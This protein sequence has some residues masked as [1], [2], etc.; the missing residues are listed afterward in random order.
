MYEG[1]STLRSNE[2]AILVIRGVVAL[3][4]GIAAVFWPGL[5]LVTL[6]YLFSAFILLSGIMT[7][8]TTAAALMDRGSS[9][10]LMKVLLALLGIVEIGVAVYMLRHPLL[11]IATFILLIGFSLIVRGVVET[12]TTLHG[13]E[14][15]TYKTIVAITGAVSVLAGV[16]ILLQPAAG[17]VAFVWVLGLF[18]LINGSMLV[19]LSLAL[20]KE[21]ELE[22]ERT[23]LLAESKGRRRQ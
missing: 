13:R 5:T 23:G 10:L 11:S 20:S 3:L 1:N 7:L 2:V 4:F 17:G 8:V 19:A 15:G 6:V 9:T 14:S 21:A 22:K 16:I 18:A 12:V